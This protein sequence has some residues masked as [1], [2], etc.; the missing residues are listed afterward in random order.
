MPSYCSSCDRYFGSQLALKEHPAILSS[1]QQ[2]RCTRCDEVFGGQE[3]LNQHLV[4]PAYPYICIDCDRPFRTQQRLDQHMQHSAVH[5]RR[6]LPQV[7][8][9]TKL[10]PQSPSLKSSISI[11]RQPVRQSDT[12]ASGSRTPQVANYG[13]EKMYPDKDDRWSVIPCSQHLAVLELLSMHCHSPADLLEHEYLLSPHNTQN[14]TGL[15]K[16]RKCGCGS[17]F[18]E[19]MV[20]SASIYLN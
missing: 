12:I 11:S 4:L 18:R 9:S 2:F 16:C 19:F 20:A 10:V 1:P 3:A 14:L 5:K 13:K 6:A 8:T 17:K 15:R 7:Q